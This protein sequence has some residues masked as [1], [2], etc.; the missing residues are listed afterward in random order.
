M[1]DGDA[2]KDRGVRIDGDM[3]LDDGVTGNVKH[4]AVLIIAE[5][6]STQGNTL[7]EGDVVAKSEP[8]L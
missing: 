2:S 3:V 8:A 4:V 6:L 5:T 7:I 1:T